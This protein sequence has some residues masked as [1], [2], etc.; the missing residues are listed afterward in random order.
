VATLNV[1][2]G[3]QQQQRVNGEE[4]VAAVGGRRLALLDTWVDAMDMDQFF[5]ALDHAVDRADQVVVANHNVNSLALHQRD[6][7]FRAFYRRADLVFIDG[8]PVVF[9]ARLLGYAVTYLERL[10]VLE[11]IWP[12]F[13][14]A[15]ARR[16]RIVHV[17]SHPSVIASA[18]E[19]IRRTVP[20]I[21]LVTLPG[22]FDHSPESAE[23]MSVVE[24]IRSADPQ[25]ILVGMGMPLQERWLLN[26]LDLLPSCIVITVGGI[27]G[28]LGQERPTA[29]RWMG[30]LGLEWVFRLATEPRR[31]WRRYLVEPAV[32]LPPLLHQ[33][34]AVRRGRDVRQIR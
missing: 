2:H 32:L 4:L 17:G 5:A 9:A 18:T 3:S 13:Q 12:L 1:Q 19:R 7:A 14:R 20:D 11:W 16:W 23:S 21:D 8:M 30:P 6:P 31:L 34:R 25:V 10:A 33:A 24:E 22:F 27:L 29:P 15:A 28:F 26:H